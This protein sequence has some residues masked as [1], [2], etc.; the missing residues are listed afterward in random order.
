MSGAGAAFGT[1]TGAFARCQ[2]SVPRARPKGVYRAAR[3]RYHCAA[4]DQPG[5]PDVIVIGRAARI[6]VDTPVAVS[7]LLVHLRR[8]D[9]PRARRA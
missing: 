6:Q 7:L 3:R 9:A 4:M 2:R 1:L 8:R 5:R